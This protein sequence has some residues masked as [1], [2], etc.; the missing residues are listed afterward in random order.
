[1]SADEELRF[2]EARRD[3]LEW[4]VKLEARRA[5]RIAAEL[6]AEEIR[7]EQLAEELDELR[8]RAAR[9]LELADLGRPN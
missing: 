9:F 2:L 3:S 1:M 8:A 4:L 7:R 5:Q 6:E